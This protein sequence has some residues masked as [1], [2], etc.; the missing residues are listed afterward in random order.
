[1]L[2]YQCLHTKDLLSKHRKPNFRD[3]YFP[4]SAIR[5]ALCSQC[6]SDYLVS[7]ADPFDKHFLY[8]NTFCTLKKKKRKKKEKLTKQF[9][10][11]FRSDYVCGIS[12]QLI[13]PFD[14]LICRMCWGGQKSDYSPPGNIFK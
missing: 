13:D 5:N 6:A 4:T 2:P 8:I 10:L 9:A 7:E 11:G 3:S 12:N 14:V 1:M